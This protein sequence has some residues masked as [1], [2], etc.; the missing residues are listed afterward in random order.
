MSWA[1]PALSRL[2]PLELPRVQGLRATL[3]T[4]GVTVALSMLVALL[5]AVWPLVRTSEGWTQ[6]LAGR[7][8]GGTAGRSRHRGRA[9]LVVTQIAFAVSL[10][11]G[12]GLLVDGLRVLRQTDPGFDP[13]DSW[14]IDLH[15]SQLRYPDDAALWGFH[16]AVLERVS[17]IPGVVS[18]GMGEVIPVSGGYGCTVQAFEDEGVYT[19][20]NASGLN[21]CAGQQRVTPGY[22]AA[23]GIPL[24]EGRLLEEGDFDDPS[25]GSVVV[26]SAFAERFWPGRSP[27]GEGVG[28]NGRNEPPF[29]RVVGVVGDVKKRASD[30]RPP[31]GEAAVAIYYPG[32]HIP[33]SEGNWG[34]WWPGS[35]TLVVSTDGTAGDVTAAVRRAVLEVDTETPVANARSMED[36]V[37]GAMASLSFLST[38]MAIAAVVALVL[39][40][41]GLYGIVSYVVS[42]RRR[43]IGMRLAIGARPVTVVR[44]IVSRTARL[45]LLGIAIGVPLAVLTVRL[46]RSALVG[47]EPTAPLAYLG[48]SL[49]V[50]VVALLAGWAPARRA[51]AIDPVESLRYDEA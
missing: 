2:A 38:L 17:G 45:V 49:T 21:T 34:F 44:E 29:F 39:A 18:A 36:V 8:R 28:P 10:L 7:A 25:R 27:I 33:E 1:I 42:Q 11:V 46:G 24:L 41:V 50:A 37:A 13:T 43:E 16:R 9:A 48:A 51:A 12:A 26:S 23:L 30:G 20:I 40:T 14:A 5:V 15:A 35:T 6:G 19:H 3:G 22:F 47:I 31:L 4:A 32:V